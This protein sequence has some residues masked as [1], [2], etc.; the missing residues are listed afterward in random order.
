M[1]VRM[2]V[3]GDSEAVFIKNTSPVFRELIFITHEY[4]KENTTKLDLYTPENRN[5]Q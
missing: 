2:Y 3:S 4:T 5:G 1:L